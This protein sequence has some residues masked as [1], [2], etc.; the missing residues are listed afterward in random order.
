MH[1]SKH[2]KSGEKERNKEKNQEG[3]RE[4]DAICRNYGHTSD[5]FFTRCGVNSGYL[6]IY[7][8]DCTK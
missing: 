4:S 8:L 2:V 7:T 1:W 5:F 3:E 6:A